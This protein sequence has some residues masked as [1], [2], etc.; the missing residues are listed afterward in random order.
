MSRLRSVLPYLALLGFALFTAQPLLRPEMICSDDGPFHIHKAI[1]LEQ[2]IRAGHFFGR[3]MPQM[4]HGFGFP[5]FNY[6]APLA[7]YL[8]IGL[9]DL[10][11]IYPAAFYLFLFLCVWLA[12]VGTYWFVREWWGDAAGLAAAVVYMTAPYL[13]FDIMIRGAL[14]ETFALVW[15]P[16]ILFTLHRALSR[17][18]ELVNGNRKSGFWSLR[19]GLWDFLAAFAFAALMYAHNTTALAA[20]PLA[21]GYVACLAL[22]HRDWRKL[23][24]GGVILFTGL[25][26]SARFWLPALA[27]RNL[28]QSDRLLV[29]P[30]FT[31]YTNFLTLRELLAL[32]AAIDPQL[33]NPSPAKGLGLVAA[34]LAL[35][36]L[37]AIAYRLSRIADRAPSRNPQPADFPLPPGPPAPQLGLW[38]LGFGICAFLAFLTY[39]LLT[40]PFTRPVWDH[41]PLMPFIQFPWRLLGPAA[42]C[43]SILAGGGIHWLPKRPWL[44]AAI[45]ALVASLG[46]LSW[47]YPRY[48]EKFAEI[49]LARTVEYERDTG[50]IGATAKGEFLPVTAHRFPDDETIADA[51]IR[52]EPPQY[53]T[54][55][56]VE[57][58]LAVTDPDTLDYRATV[59]TPVAF[60]ITFN[61]FYFP[62]WRAT[63]DDRPT[64]IQLTPDTG[65]MT[66]LIPAGKHTLHFHFGETPLRAASDAVSLIALLGLMAYGVSRIAYRSIAKHP[67][68]SERTPHASLSTPPA[69]P[70]PRPP[71]PLHLPLGF[72]IWILGFLLFALRIV[73]IDR[74]SNPLRHTAFNREAGTVAV[75]QT[76]RLAD[77]AG[78]VRL[79]G[80]DLSS[81]T[82]PGD[83][84]MDA[85]LYVSVRAHVER[86]YW[87][88]FNFVGADGLTW[89]PGYFLPPRWHKEPT[90]TSYWSPDQYAQWARHLTL[91]PGAPPGQYELVGEIF[92]VDSLQIASMLDAQ[93]NAVA[94]RFSLG[95]VTVT[96]PRTPFTLSPE[97]PTLPAFE[98]IT[99]IGYNLSLEGAKAG[100]TV[101]LTL[102]W[103]SESATA[104]DYTAHIALLTPDG[105]SAFGVD[106][107]P[108]AAYPTRQWQPGDEWRGQHRLRLPASLADGEYQLSISLNGEP[109]AQALG[110]IRVTAPTR[111]FAR[112]DVQFEKG[113][114]FEG[115]AALEGYSLKTEGNTLTVTLVWRAT[116]TPDASYSSF[117]HLSDD[118]GRI[119]SQSDSV[120]ANWT[121][122]TTGWLAG[123][124]V[125]DAHTLTLPGD[126]PP[127]AYRLLV[128]LYDPQSATRVPASGVGV[129]ADNRVEI[130]SISLP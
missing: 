111:A 20:A 47:W 54:G 125:V 12:G 91:L 116:A 130:G 66:L 123:E 7:S 9:H 30:I 48:C 84:F 26:L 118:T 65:L 34:L 71:A 16:I 89:N 18:W 45:I 103:K 129:G 24:Q 17:H 1:V 96:R 92:D 63:L 56:P 122:P 95:T 58:Q 99:L 110:T 79:Y 124:Y 44:L 77:F 97:H 127:G 128:G 59:T 74:T 78:G 5:H 107:P 40:L 104:K 61:Q 75:A 10:G 119:W 121:R 67:E 49:T 85:S 101:L 14:A 87:P 70:L 42:L 29:P 50:T 33:V 6:Y 28:V 64:A 38:D 19:F 76:P 81:T 102:Y 69:P 93:G 27:E 25:A 3:W 80:Y 120:P 72:G 36:G 32:P 31:Y 117:V 94:P 37:A 62:G 11:L 41:I 73:V 90:P 57:A 126:L 105:R 68:R 113:A 112:P 86:R 108:V 55:F 8:L 2:V 23:V 22:L 115:V 4:A 35:A 88:A 13:A 15:P 60:R 52:G 39:A 43:A 53:L 51:L 106:L 46:H 98:P 21:A 109:G 82:M 83:E 100:D 114:S